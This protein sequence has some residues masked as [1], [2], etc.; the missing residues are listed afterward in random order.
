MDF[1]CW[2]RGIPRGR[3][4]YQISYLEGCSI[5]HTLKILVMRLI[6]FGGASSEGVDKMRTRLSNMTPLA[7]SG[8]GGL[9]ASWRGWDANTRG[10][11]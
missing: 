8:K 11:A 6:R 2:E 4:P 9:A 1:V 10:R 5:L 7:Q 3:T